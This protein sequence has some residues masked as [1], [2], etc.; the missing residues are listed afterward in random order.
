[1]KTLLLLASV[2]LLMALAGCLPAR[3]PPSP[4]CARIRTMGRW[5]QRDAPDRLVAV[6]PGSSFAFRYR[7]TSCVLHFDVSENKPPWPQLWVRLDGAWS[8]HTVDRSEVV[9]GEEAEEGVHEAW[10]VLKSADEHQRR[11]APPLVAALRLTGVRAPGGRLLP[12]PGPRKRVLEAVGDSITEGVLAHRRGKLSEWTEIADSRATYAFRTAVAL[13]AEP[14]I[15]GFGAQGITK[16]GNGGVPPAPLAYPYVYQGVPAQDRPADIVVVN[17]GSNDRRA[18]SIENGTGNLLKLIRQHNPGAAIFCMVPFAPVHR[19]SITAA[20]AHARAAGDLRV[21][22]VETR[23]WLD[24]KTDTTDG[25]HPNVQ[26]HAKAARKLV[27]VI[28]GVLD[29]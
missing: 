10:V 11:W 27:E 7:G 20:V 5:D 6:N 18:P 25:A 16:G 12:P 14:R 3:R 13:D 19:K 24:P 15:I 29:L 17:H 23:G 1:M 28:R 4:G 21:Y 2:G 26:G 22:L 9:V 8:Q